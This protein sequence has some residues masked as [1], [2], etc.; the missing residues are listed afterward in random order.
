MRSIYAACC[1]LIIFSSCLAQHTRS[2]EPIYAVGQPGIT[3]P[4]SIFTP[5]PISPAEMKKAKHER[6]AMLS[7]YV[8]MDGAVHDV[9]VVRSTGDSGLDTRA[10][11]RVVTWKFRPCTK[12]GTPVNC[13]LILE[14]TFHL[15]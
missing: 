13:S 14:A 15:Y 8:G 1:A 4:Q 6:V 12:N 3:P 10:V 9:K 11:E 7:A 5:S 2:G